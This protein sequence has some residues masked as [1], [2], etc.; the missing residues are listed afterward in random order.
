MKSLKTQ[1]A[2]LIISDSSDVSRSVSEVAITTFLVKI[3][4]SGFSRPVHLN[5]IIK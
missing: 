1:S 4:K 2:I 5:V 3:V